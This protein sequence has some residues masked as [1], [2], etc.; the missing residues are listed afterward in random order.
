MYQ[1]N[2]LEASDS[3]KH[4]RHLITCIY[5]TKDHQSISNV[6]TL[7]KPCTTRTEERASIS[8]NPRRPLD[9]ILETMLSLGER[10]IRFCAHAYIFQGL[11]PGPRHALWLS[12]HF[13]LRNAGCHSKKRGIVASK[14]RGV[15]VDAS[16]TTGCQEKPGS[17]LFSIFCP[18]RMFVPASET[19]PQISCAE[20]TRCIATLKRE[21]WRNCLMLEQL[22]SRST[23]TVN[24]SVHQHGWNSRPLDKLYQGRSRRHNYLKNVFD[25]SSTFSEKSQNIHHYNNAELPPHVSWRDCR[26]WQL[27]PPFFCSSSC[28]FLSR[29]ILI[30]ILRSNPSSSV[31]SKAA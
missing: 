2:S 19:L 3:Q 24:E 12:L 13:W 8:W 27:W 14:K 1:A 31:P 16:A 28:Q 11:F 4:L 5:T 6:A 18:Q 29:T 30:D 9:E 7:C 26:L 10:F 25:V 20:G 15:D 21:S 23:V 17:I 22:R